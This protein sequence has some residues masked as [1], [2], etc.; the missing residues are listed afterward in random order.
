VVSR[1]HSGARLLP[2]IILEPGNEAPAG[3]GDRANR[4]SIWPPKIPRPT[5]EK[6]RRSRRVTYFR[7]KLRQTWRRMGG[8]V[9]YAIATVYF[10]VD[11][12]FL[13][14]IRPLRRRLLGGG[15]L[16][17]WVEGLKRY[18]ALSLVLVPLAILEPVKP[19]GFYLTAKGHLFSGGSV[20]AIGEII[21]VT[22]VEQVI[23]ITKP[24]L[25]S[26]HWF[27]WMYSRWEA[28]LARLHSIRTFQAIKRQVKSMAARVRQMKS[29]M[30]LR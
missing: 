26:F 7:T 20:I 28:V 18:V 12:V 10:I 3:Q 27:A 11:L 1:R 25:L 13:S 6:H 29:G 21:K 17:D 19:V 14:F 2:W 16:H 22:L 8:A 4:L 24:K 5:G 15:R 23:E 30:E 9:L